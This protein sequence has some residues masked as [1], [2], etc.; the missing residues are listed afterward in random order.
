MCLQAC[1]VR[2]NAFQSGPL[3]SLSST[4]QESL[5]NA[6]PSSMVLVVSRSVLA[7]LNVI[8][9][10]DWSLLSRMLCIMRLQCRAHTLI[11]PGPTSAIDRPGQLR[12]CCEEDHDTS[13]A[14]FAPPR[15]YMCLI[16]L[17][18]NDLNKLPGQISAACP[19]NEHQ[20]APE[21]NF[22]LGSDLWLQDIML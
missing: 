21:P 17:H 1:A 15:C 7:D 3:V 9:Y 2:R 5:A 10:S 6:S 12:Q 22:I 14:S 4:T 11:N 18:S 13:D 8:Q 20:P 16:C 19:C